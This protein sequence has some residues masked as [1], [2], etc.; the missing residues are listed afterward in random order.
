MGIKK[1]KKDNIVIRQRSRD[2]TKRF[3]ILLDELTSLLPINKRIKYPTKF[4]ILMASID[5][6]KSLISEKKNQNKYNETSSFIENC[7]VESECLSTEN[8]FSSKMDAG[9]GPAVKPSL[10]INILHD[11]ECDLPENIML[12]VFD[13]SDFNMLETSTSLLDQICENL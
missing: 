9:D 13:L 11:F 8:K 1:Y 7:P 2:Q 10:D 5:L 12:S 4:S 6:I 3:R